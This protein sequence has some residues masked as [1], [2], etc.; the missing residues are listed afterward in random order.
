MGC[1][2]QTPPLKAQGSNLE[3]E[4]DT[5]CNNQWWWITLRKQCLLDTKGLMHKELIEI[6]AASTRPAQV[7]AGCSH[8]AESR[9]DVEFHPWPRNYLQLIPAGKVFSS[10][11]P[12]DTSASLKGRPHGQEQLG[13]K[14]NSV[15]FLWAFCFCCFSFTFCLFVCLLVFCLL[16]FVS[17]L[18][19]LVFCGLPGIFFLFISCS[20]VCCLFQKRGKTYLG[21]CREV[22]RI[23]EDGGGG[24]TIKIH[25]IRFFSRKRK[26]TVYCK[27]LDSLP[28]F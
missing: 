7:Q 13:N 21:V 14:T 23:W 18:A 3:G 12:V 27:Y 25:C 5:T 22:G 8:S 6:V 11:V 17:L 20:F 1:F 4:A 2:H 9:S 26:N 24:N 19:L 16:L 28:Q 10:G 15:V